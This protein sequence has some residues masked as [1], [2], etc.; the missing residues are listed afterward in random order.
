MRQFGQEFALLNQSQSP[1]LGLERRDEPAG[2]VAPV[3]TSNSSRLA[4][5]LL[6]SGVPGHRLVEEAV[7]AARI[8]A[9]LIDLGLGEG[10]INE[11][12]ILTELAAL[13]DC[14]MMTEPPP[15]IVGSDFANCVARRCYRG[16]AH[17]HAEP[18]LVIAPNG[19][20][21]RAL[22]N[23][24]IKAPTGR[25]ILTRQQALRDR[26]MTFGGERLARAAAST[27]PAALSA[28]PDSVT[29]G[30]A[31]RLVMLTL[32]ALCLL[33]L[34]QLVIDPHY[35][36]RLVPL[37]LGPVFILAASVTAIACLA[38]M[39]RVPPPPV[40]ADKDLPSY[41][42]LVPLY[43][44]ARVLDA[45]VARLAALD[46]PRDR[47][48]ILL[49]VE[50]H[51]SQTREALAPKIPHFPRSLNV[52]V[53]PQGEPR[54][55]PR[56][57]NAAM[58]FV[59]GDY[60]VVY[61]AE[62]AP[63]P[64]QLRRAAALFAASPPDVACLQARLAIANPWDGVLPM[65]FALDYAALF[66]LVK[67]GTARIGWP[68]PLGGTSNHLRTADLRAVG[69]WDAWNVTEDADLGIRLARHGKRVQ[70]LPSTTWEEAP[71]EAGPWLNQ[72]TRWMKGWMQTL[73]V[74]ARS[75]LRLVREIGLVASASL[76][77]IG[78][79][80]IICSLML[81]L[82]I[83]ATLV[84]MAV[85][86]ALFEGTI[87]QTI[88]DGMLVISVCLAIF[89]EIVPPAVALVR[90]R[91]FKLLP[92]II[93][94]PLTYLMISIASW[95]ALYDLVRRPYHWHKTPHGLMRREG[96]MGVLPGSPAQTMAQT[97]QSG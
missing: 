53:V 9:D 82:V 76:G 57:L 93:L 27:L 55:K 80:M 38:G 20:M 30:T 81:P 12:T 83:A 97:G 64:D 22:L 48:D 6:S 21:M 46:Y 67:A 11:D 94:A 86:P 37:A 40:L 77:S 51:D 10:W 90:R 39:R 79:S 89:L 42:L 95:R 52:L 16:R 87:A 47:L 73:L 88:A 2:A 25:L 65:R 56:A 29:G 50:Q 92:A 63:D 69:A 72:R 26:L 66:D 45:L 59:T 1:S 49:L 15:P 19:R 85:G 24:T 36:L 91:S 34:L 96:G 28:R 41:T 7:R 3:R 35:L 54:T 75:P 14:V 8:G 13:L 23:G 43:R 4:T 84:R 71:V 32:P 31:G 68:V 74:H 18:S 58:P 44:E 62:D 17:I 60:V 78:L 33:L 61:D 5:L 70:D